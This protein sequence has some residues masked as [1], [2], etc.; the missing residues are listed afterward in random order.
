MKTKPKPSPKKKARARRTHTRSSIPARAT[1]A[2]EYVLCGKCPHKHGPYWYAYWKEG[3]K[4]RKRYVGSHVALARLI[5]S[6]GERAGRDVH[7][8][9]FEADRKESYGGQ[10]SSKGPGSRPRRPW[11]RGARAVL[12][13]SARMRGGAS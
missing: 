2:R 3:N 8:E 12:R 4:S 5:D 6:W 13:A 11:T 9:E 1:L 7:D 10:L